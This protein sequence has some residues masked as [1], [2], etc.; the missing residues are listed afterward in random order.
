MLRQSPYSRHNCKSCSN[1]LRSVFSAGEQFDLSA[2]WTGAWDR[3]A[4]FSFSVAS[5][6]MGRALVIRC[7]FAEMPADAVAMHRMTL[8]GK[9]TADFDR[10]LNDGKRFDIRSRMTC[11]RDNAEVSERGI[12]QRSF[13]RGARG[14]SST[15]SKR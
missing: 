4:R 14:S 12:S 8:S 11:S 7:N 3:N 13:G 1:L 2:M 6:E 15:K 5:K 10:S 9:T